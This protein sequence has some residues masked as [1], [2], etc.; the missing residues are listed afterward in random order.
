MYPWSHRN[1]SAAGGDTGVA[2]SVLAVR[3]TAVAP[4]AVASRAPAT[5]RRREP[6]PVADAVHVVL[7][8]IWSV[9]AE[10]FMTLIVHS[11]M[12]PQ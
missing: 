11:A 3:P 1:A 4:I 2:V 9:F 10:V 7:S 6:V 12:V 8:S 5:L